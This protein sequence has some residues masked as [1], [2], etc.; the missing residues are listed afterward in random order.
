LSNVENGETAVVSD[1]WRARRD[2]LFLASCIS[3][4]VTA[5]SFAIRGDIMGALG[6]QFK[7]TNE[8]VGQIAGTAFWGFTLSMLIG[9]PLCDV[10]GM[11]RIMFL[12]FVGHLS[13]ILLTIFAG[14]YWGLYA[15][16]LAIG[17]GNGFVEAACNPL[18]AT[19]YPD[20]KIKRLNLFHVWFPGGI[21]I[22]GLVAYA[23]TQFGIGMTEQGGAGMSW[24]IK[25]ASMLIPLVIYGFLFFGQKFP[26]TERVAAGVST[27]QMFA[28]CLTPLFLVFVVCMIMTAV[29]ELGPGQWIPN[30]V[31]ITTGASGI[32]FLVWQNGLMAVGRTFA[33]P[34]VHRLSPSGILLFSAI[35]SAIGLYM[36][37]V[38]TT[39]LMAGI[40]ITVFAVGV[41]FFWPTMLGNVSE[42]F[43]RTG[44]LGLAIMGAVGMLASSFAPPYIGKQYDAT[45][46]SESLAYVRSVTSNPPANLQDRSSPYIAVKTAFEE[47]K[48]KGVTDE[49]AAVAAL[50]STG[51]VNPAIAKAARDAEAKGGAAG[52]RTVVVLP[53]IL[54]FIFGA[55]FLY[56]KSRGGFRQE[57][58]HQDANVPA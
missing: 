39:P 22:G 3:L 29:T 43:P 33:G 16:T 35:F 32:L 56:D 48:K 1:Y 45:T 14:G 34:I 5:M 4:I 55:I 23:I 24:Q 41:C 46:A 36:L 7:L 27:A 10:L 19:L 53:I 20:Q 42:R 58:L 2:R 47:E 11:G 40:A 37:S 26:A 31:S 52:L 50:K 6:E 38:A 9:G 44:S 18:V 28:A 25:M 54:I 30:I 57:V 17:L 8:Q 49:A 21:V 12:A 13:G 51:G 15:G